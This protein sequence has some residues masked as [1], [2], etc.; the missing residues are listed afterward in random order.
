MRLLAV[1]NGRFPVLMRVDQAQW[2]SGL[3]A[4]GRMY[5]PVPGGTH[6]HYME[7]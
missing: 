1:M 6:M 7:L 5:T 3:S 4:L 2:P